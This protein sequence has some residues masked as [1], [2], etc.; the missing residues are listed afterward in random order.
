LSGGTH[1]KPHYGP[2]NKKLRVHLPLIVPSFTS[3][4]S[5]S[6]PL[7]LSLLSSSAAAAAT[8]INTTTAS[9]TN[10]S[11]SIS[12]CQSQS[13]HSHSQSSCRLVVGGLSV[14]VHEGKIIIFD[15][16]FLHE[17]YNDA[18]LDDNGGN[19]IRAVLVFDIWHPDFSD[20]E[21]HLI[22]ILLKIILFLITYFLQLIEEIVCCI[23]G[24]ISEI[25]Y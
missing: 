20:E 18:I 22:L 6:S 5:S 10:I 25:C 4:Q 24:Q 19:S 3:S 21:V 23:A 17:A 14:P 8:E 16:S 7:S 15:D 9:V 13:A 11:R 1:V 12:D 2:T